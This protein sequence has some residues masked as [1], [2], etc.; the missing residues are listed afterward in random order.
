MDLVL[1]RLASPLGK[2]LL[3]S[4]GETLSALDFEDEAPRMMR[5]LRRHWGNCALA[6]APAPETFRRALADYFAGDLG[7]L[8]PLPVRTNGTSF[9]R[10]VWAALRAIPAGATTS[11]GAL[12]AKLGKPGAS[13]A[14]GRANGANPVAIVVPCHRVIG[15][16]GALT[17]YAGGLTRKRWLL[18]HEGALGTA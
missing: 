17:G 2:L 5:L 3:V 4:D 1:S 15:G 14:V 13:R 10:A 6:R 7:A 12:A 8:E 11:Y 16:G 18:A 9:Q